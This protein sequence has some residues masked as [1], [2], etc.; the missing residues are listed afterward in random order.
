MS[1]IS[2]EYRCECGWADIKINR[3]DSR[4]DSVECPECGEQAGKIFG[5]AFMTTALP[6]GT[7]RFDGIREQRVLEK[8]KRKAWKTRDKKEGAKVASEIKKLNS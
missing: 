6:D 2:D 7:R 1:R 3:K 8:A 4:P 5:C